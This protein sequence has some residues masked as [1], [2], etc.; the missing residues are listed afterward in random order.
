VS[1]RPNWPTLEELGA[2][3]MT[4]G[5]LDALATYLS[6]LAESAMEVRHLQLE[7]RHRLLEGI[8]NRPAIGFY[9]R[10]RDENSA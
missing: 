8:P 3:S 10:L 2:R 6:G 7:R 9:L 5:E 4:P 1:A